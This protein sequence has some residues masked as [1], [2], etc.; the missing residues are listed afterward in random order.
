MA[1][2]SLNGGSCS[3]NMCVTPALSPASTIGDK[4]GNAFWLRAATIIGRV[5][6]PCGTKKMRPIAQ[7][8]DSAVR[9]KGLHAHPK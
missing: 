8:M 1:G 4:Q 9:A 3:K 6:C 7:E 5:F 2:T